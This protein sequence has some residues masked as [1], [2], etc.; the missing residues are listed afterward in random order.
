M[1]VGEH[2]NADLAGQRDDG[3][4]DHASGRSR[5]GRLF[6]RRRAEPSLLDDQRERPDRPAEQ[7][8]D[9]GVRA[10]VRGHL[11]EARR[12]VARLANVP[13]DDLTRAV[14]DLRL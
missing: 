14:R 3:R 13:V 11:T 2:L 8:R 7:V 5:A 1:A 10:F 4:V 12:V 9:D 6:A